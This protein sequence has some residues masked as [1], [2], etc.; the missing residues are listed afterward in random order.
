MIRGTG[1]RPDI[2]FQTAVAANKY[3]MSAPDIVEET[4]KEVEQLTGRK[5]SLFDY[6]GSPTAE[7]VAVCMG[8]AA[9]TLE[10]TV[11]FMNAQGE[12]VGVLSV[13][14]FR[15]WSAK[16]FLAALPKTVKKIAVL[17]KTREEGKYQ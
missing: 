5:Y 12:N 14:L 6:H 15:P 9:M 1:Q 11:D 3:Y 7:R 17:D 13:H 16:H 2:F 4:L 8:S 10:E